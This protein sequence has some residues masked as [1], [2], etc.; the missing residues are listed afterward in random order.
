MNLPMRA[1]FGSYP[2]AAELDNLLE[3]GVTIIVNLTES[4][5]EGIQPYSVPSKCEVI[6]YPIKDNGVPLNWLSYTQLI[7][8]LTK[9]I[10]SGR[11]VFIHC[12]AGHS[13]SSMVCASIMCQLDSLMHPEVAIEKISA[14]HAQRESLGLKWKKMANPLSR[15]QQIFLYKFFSTI[16]FC[17]AYQS[18][19]QTG[20]SSFS[21]HSV[22]V[23][24]ETFPNAEAAF[25]Y[26]KDPSDPVFTRKL[27]D[28]KK[29]VFVKLIGDDHWLEETR[30]FDKEDAMYAVCKLKYEQHH[31]LGLF[32]KKTYL[33]RLYDGC[34]YSHA[35]NLV[36]NALMKLREEMFS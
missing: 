32:L 19:T 36:G 34:K 33:R 26:L 14:I 5:E 24:N 13:R 10:K 27:V 12:R 18:G 22:K 31:E 25:Q 2:T 28:A 8:R 23:G 29:F 3:E 6:S 11:C 7:L 20:F 35:N 15:A 9:D 16:Y 30:E 21:L 4:D 1:F 17:K